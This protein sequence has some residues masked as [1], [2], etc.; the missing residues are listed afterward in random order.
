MTPSEFKELKEHLKDLLDKGL[1]KHG[2]SPKGA[3]V[4]FIM[5][6]DGSL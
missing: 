1:I 3:P 4:L 6:K 5:K 2:I